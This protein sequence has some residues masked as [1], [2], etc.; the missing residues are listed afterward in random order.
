MAG[1]YIWRGPCGGEL[2]FR[3]RASPAAAEWFVDLYLGMAATQSSTVDTTFPG[4]VTITQDLDVLK[5][6]TVGARGGY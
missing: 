3:V 5:N 1:T 6:V 4:G 2:A